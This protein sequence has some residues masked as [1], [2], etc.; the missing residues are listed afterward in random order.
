MRA[1]TLR[2]WT[3]CSA[4]GSRKGG[5]R[6]VDV[7]EVTL[8]APQLVRGNGWTMT[9]TATFEGVYRGYEP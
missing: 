1:A 2:T 5:G 4:P 7:V 9:R 8:R 3:G 6:D